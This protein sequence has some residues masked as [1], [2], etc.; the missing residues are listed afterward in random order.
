MNAQAPRRGL[1]RGLG[2]LI[3]T[4]PPV[5]PTFQDAD[6]S[7][8]ATSSPSVDPGSTDS[9]RGPQIEDSGLAPVEGA[10]F[11]ELPVDHIKPNAVNPRTVFDEDAMAE[12]V[13]S[14][15]EIGL[16]QPVVV[17]RTGPDAFELVMG[18]RRWRATQQAGLATIPAI[19]RETEDT[20][21]LRDALLENLHRS[22]LNP[23]EEAAA[24]QQ[25]L[26]DFACTHEELAQRIG[27]SRPQISNTMR[28]LKLSPAVQRRVAAGVLSA[29]H[30]RALL[31]VSEAD[32]Q[33]RLAQ[34]VVAE[35]ISVRG[36]EEIVAVGDVGGAAPRPQRA[37]PKAPGLVELSDRLGDRLETRVKIDLGKAKGKIS[38]EFANT[39][40]LQRIVDLI[41]PRNRDDRPI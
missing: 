17:R 39:G 2:S 5:N 26:E 23:L 29:G 40:D 15:R 38:I 24:Y 8:G 9:A 25:L 1:G 33:D 37:R 21:M 4:A 19:V 11:A 13:H 30:A 12:L 34:R 20:A 7:A 28:L 31:G 3:P 32:L 22:N 18:E 10:Y 35:G 16:L 41:D 6:L 36:L 27:R 14:I